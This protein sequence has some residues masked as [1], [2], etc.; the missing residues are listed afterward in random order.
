MDIKLFKISNS[1]IK[2]VDKSEIVLAPTKNIIEGRWA[3]ANK[4]AEITVIIQNTIFLYFPLK[5]TLEIN[6]TQKVIKNNLKIIS[7]P[8]PA[9]NEAKNEVGKGG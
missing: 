4:I 8:I 5:I 7:S 3:P 9:D 1:T 2:I 6:Q